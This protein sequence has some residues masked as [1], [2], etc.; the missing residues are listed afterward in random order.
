MPYM[1]PESKNEKESPNQLISSGI[2]LFF[3]AEHT[4]KLPTPLQ[5]ISALEPQEQVGLYLLVRT[6]H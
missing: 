5:T 6:K 4:L 1:F 3:F 2:L